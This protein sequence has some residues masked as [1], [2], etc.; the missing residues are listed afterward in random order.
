MQPRACSERLRRRRNPAPFGAFYTNPLSTATET[1]SQMKMTIKMALA[2]MTLFILMPWGLICTQAAGTTNQPTAAELQPLQ[3]SWEG[4]LVGQETAGKISITITGNSLH[5][6]RLNRNEWYET[7]FTLPAGTYPQ[8]LH[9]TIKD[10]TQPCDDVGKVVF[11]IFKIE[12]GTLTLAGIQ[13][14]AVEPP[15]TFGEFP[16]F[17]DDRIFRYKLKKAQPS[18]FRDD[19]KKVQPQMQAPPSGG[20]S[21]RLTPRAERPQRRQQRPY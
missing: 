1:K 14:S 2:V 17:E 8:Q 3:G 10:C 5:F 9:A 20:S 11:A 13:A 19:L 7:T 6:Q 15:K 21:G 4:V 18:I 12:D 16:G